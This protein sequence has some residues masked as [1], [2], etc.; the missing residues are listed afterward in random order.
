L[1]YDADKISSDDDATVRV[2]TP[3]DQDIQ[4][5]FDLGHLR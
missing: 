3:D 1:Q 4:T 2:H 5:V